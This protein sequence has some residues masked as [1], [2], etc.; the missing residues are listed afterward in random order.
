MAEDAQSSIPEFGDRTPGKVYVPRPG[1]YGL[2]FDAKGRI[3]VTET[4]RGCFLPGGGLE[5]GETPKEAL[6]REA[7]EECGFRITIGRRLGE[8]A[9]YRDTP[10]HEFA[11]RKD[12]IF[13]AAQITSA[14]G[15]ATEAGHTL[16]WLE[17]T[18]AETR[19]A[20]GSQQWAVRQ[21]REVSLP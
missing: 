14:G 11:I 18:E 2:I 16:I 19:L 8:A 3:A 1:A 7:S 9:E 20:H 6:V 15:A 21:Y 17:P 13:F 5:A 12:C 10:G 4:P